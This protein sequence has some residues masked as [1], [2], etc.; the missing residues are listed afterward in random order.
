MRAYFVKKL[1]VM[2]MISAFRSLLVVLIANSILSCGDG[3]SPETVV[4]GIF[5]DLAKI[6]KV[7]LKVKTE[8]D[9]ETAKKEIAVIQKEILAKAEKLDAMEV[10][11]EEEAKALEAKVEESVNALKKE[12]D[13]AA[14]HMESLPNEELKAKFRE[15]MA[16]V[17]ESREAV[18][19]K[20][21]RLEGKDK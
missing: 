11:T 8:A 16:A 21:A 6:P 3:D 2:K 10:M 20:L 19:P 4:V 9:L 12:M 18:V 7:A 5:E 1:T 14:K 13:M 15:M 17:G